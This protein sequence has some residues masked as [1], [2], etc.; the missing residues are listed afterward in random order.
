M[1][2]KS[3][4]KARTSGS[5][6]KLKKAYPSPVKIGGSSV[7]EPLSQV[8][9]RAFAPGTEPETVTCT[10]DADFLVHY[11]SNGSNNSFSINVKS[12]GF[13]TGVNPSVTSFTIGGNAND[14]IT[15]IFQPG[16]AGFITLQ[17]KYS[18]NASVIG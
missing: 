12:T 11:V 8:L 15:F 7:C 14:V 18:A 13:S 10:S 16:A 3:R 6:A 1:A 2:N 5:K 4:R 9:V 17:T